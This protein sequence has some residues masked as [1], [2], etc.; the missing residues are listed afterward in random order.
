MA[1]EKATFLF[2]SLPSKHHHHPI[3]EMG[4]IHRH[5]WEFCLAQDAVNHGVKPRHQPCSSWSRWLLGEPSEGRMAPESPSCGFHTS[6]QSRE[7]APGRDELDKL[8]NLWDQSCSFPVFSLSSKQAQDGESG[9]A[10]HILGSV[11]GHLELCPSAWA[12]FGSRTPPLAQGLLNFPV[13][14]PP[15]LLGERGHCS[16]TSSSTGHSSGENLNFKGK[17]PP[18]LPGLWAP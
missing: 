7:V 17:K 6:K 13:P 15:H 12:H 14:F 4:H 11:W 10:G 18:T 9:G 1:W 3:N 8:Q 2:L 5:W 16:V